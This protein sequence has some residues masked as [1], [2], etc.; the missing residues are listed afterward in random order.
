MCSRFAFAL[1]FC[2]ALTA[3]SSAQQITHD[4]VVERASLNDGYQGFITCGT[5]GQLYR[6][7]GNGGSHSVMRVAPDG[8][9]LLFALPEHV[10]PDAVAPNGTG[11]N[12]L[13]TIY[14]VAERRL[15]FQMVH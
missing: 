14:L 5:D 10:Y 2:A 4:V 8:S 9:S 3:A 13:S 11:T 6:R 1:L 15:H 7:S 12:I